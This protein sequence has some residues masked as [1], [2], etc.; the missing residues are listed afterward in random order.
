MRLGVFGGSFDPPHIGHF[1]A[2]VDAAERLGLDRVFWVPTAQQPLKAGTPHVASADQRFRMVQAA[3]SSNTIFESSRIEIDRSGLSYTVATVQ[4]FAAQFPGAELFLLIGED[5]WS[6]FED[7]H[8]PEKIRTLVQIEI[9][10]RK[11]ESEFSGR[12]IEVSSTEIRARA[13]DGRSVRGFVQDAVAEIIESE[14]LYQ[15]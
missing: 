4:S 3:V 5:A 12:V 10:A 13:R 11:T 7:W 15:W 6:R 2:A 9:L 1:L 8:E 14:G